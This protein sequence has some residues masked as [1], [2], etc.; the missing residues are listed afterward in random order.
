MTHT[1]GGDGV[2]VVKHVKEDG[3]VVGRMEGMRLKVYS[4]SNLF[5]R[6]QVDVIYWPHYYPHTD[7]KHPLIAE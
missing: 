1:Y 4:K 3:S 5:S 2:M 7:V 6:E